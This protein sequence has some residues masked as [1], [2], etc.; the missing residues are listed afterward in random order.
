M[1]YS[2]YLFGYYFC[3][4]KKWS[5]LSLYYF[6]QPNC[7]LLNHLTAML[8]ENTIRSTYRQIVIELGTCSVRLCSDSPIYHSTGVPI[9]IHT[10]TITL[11]RINN[12]KWC[13]YCRHVFS[14]E[15]EFLQVSTTTTSTSQRNVINL[16][17]VTERCCTVFFS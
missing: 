7:G 1:N 2:L 8:F 16:I 9:H 13:I 10:L 4:F 12:L 11:K 14:I 6:F 17:V 5:N 3:L 15:H